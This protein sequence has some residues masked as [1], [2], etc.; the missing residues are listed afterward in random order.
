MYKNHGDDEEYFTPTKL[1]YGSE[2][3]ST[4]IYHQL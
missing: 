3:V 4:Q 2:A 1:D